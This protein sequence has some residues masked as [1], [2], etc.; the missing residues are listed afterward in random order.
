MF[1]DFST[2]DTGILHIHFIGLRQWQSPWHVIIVYAYVT[3]TQVKG[4]ERTL[5]T[6]QKKT[7]W[8]SSKDVMINY[9]TLSQI[10][11]QTVFNFLLVKATLSLYEFKNKAI[12]KVCDWLR[13]S[14]PR[15]H[16]LLALSYNVSLLLNGGINNT[17]WVPY[18]VFYPWLLSFSSLKPWDPRR[19]IINIE[20]RDYSRQ[21]QRNQSQKTNTKHFLITMFM[22]FISAHV[23]EEYN[24]EAPSLINLIF[25]ISFGFLTFKFKIARFTP[26][27]E[28]LNNY[29]TQHVAKL[30]HWRRSVT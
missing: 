26:A 8:R 12:T 4:R 10:T 6:W 17:R 5:G 23:I 11:P 24:V 3:L 14:C 30:L 2:K 7:N 18:L 9:S 29:C 25:F 13:K 15:D 28:E 16:L 22:R 1:N 27:H 19:I 20:D 21:K